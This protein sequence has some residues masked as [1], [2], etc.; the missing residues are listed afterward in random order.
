MAALEHVF[1]EGAV[2]AEIIEFKD[3]DSFKAWLPQKHADMPAASKHTSSPLVTV[4]YRGK[5]TFLG[6][7]DDTKEL[8]SKL[9]S[10][11]ANVN[12]LFGQTTLPDVDDD[13]TYDYDLVVIG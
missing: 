9:F 3:R 2:T 5:D 1:G 11:K 8:A 6:G 7:W 12:D 10:G 13:A 4:A